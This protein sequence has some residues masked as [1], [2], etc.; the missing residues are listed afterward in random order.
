MPLLKP[1]LILVL[2]TLA[3]PALVRAAPETTLWYDAP[4]SAWK[5]ALPLG[6]G[7]LG[8]MVFGDPVKEHVQLNEESL[9]AGAPV[10]AWPAD[11]RRHFDEV[12][13]LVFA[14]NNVEAHAYGGKHL[15]AR[16]TAFRSYEPL[17]DLWLEFDNPPPASQPIAYRRELDLPEATARVTWQQGNA[18]FTR[19]TIISAADDVLAMRIA[20]NK[21]GALSFTV[22]L[23]RHKDA[24]FLAR[25]DGTIRMD[26]QIVDI[27]KKDGGFDDNAGGS[28][29]G[30]AHMRFAGRLAVR[31]TG[32]TVTAKGEVLRVSGANEVLLLFTAATDYSLEKLNFDPSLDPAAIAEN[33]LGKAMKKDWAALHAAHVAEHKPLFS[34]V[35]LDLGGDPSRQKVPTNARIEA[36]KSGDD[37][38]GLIALHFQFGRYLLLGSSRRPGRLPAN[39]QGIWSDRP[40]AAW[41]ADYHLN[42]NIQMNYWPARTTNLAETAEPLLGWFERLAQRGRE[43]ARR[44]YGADGWLCYLASNPFGRVTPGGST[45]GS[46]FVNSVLDP[47][48]GAW[49]AAELFDQYQFTRDRKFLERLWPIL[50]GA[51]RF[52]LES[53][54]PAPDG[55]LVICP[56]TSPENAYIDPAT[57]KKLRITYGSTYHMSLVRAIFDATDRAAAILGT[58]EETRRRIAEAGAKLPP[59]RIGP[60]G[61]IL[62]WIEPYPEAE[63]G[64]RHISHLVGLHPFDQITRETPDLMEGA[65][66]VIESRLNNGG[67]G[68][69]WSR[70]W[71]INFSARLGDGDAAQGHYLELLRRSTWPNLLNVHPPFQIDGNLG[72][73]AGLAEM[74]VQSQQRKPGSKAGDEEFIIELLPAL[75]KAWPD[76]K[77][78]GLTARGGLVV[79]I[80][81]KNGKLTSYQLRSEIPR[82]VMVRIGN[83]TRTVTTVKR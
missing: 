49:L 55:S 58:G 48:C 52:V 75:P 81:W 63:P 60:D 50:D 24:K 65:R 30:G 21:P 66:K 79:D 51:S 74:L 7:R 44:L 2:L 6:N 32:G 22:Q 73:P 76:G 23:A 56:S 59:I 69:G 26:G 72:A 11:F 19:E 53:L 35:S 64:H 15:T 14:G 8:A 82:P 38:P 27:E 9:W 25:P 36:V 39:L 40:W 78:T 17:G 34:R 62:E 46:Q 61:R 41:E 57:G 71:I 31:A 5:E 42:I 4:A 77:V 67:A 13:R 43:S 33:I 3:A 70:A 12:R 68:P 47:L 1:H 10:E 16:P 37:D 20:S 29:P 83:E 18:T 28:G 54:V 45:P 80:E